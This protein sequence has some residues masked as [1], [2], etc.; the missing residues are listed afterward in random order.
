VGQK[1][2]D[3]SVQCLRAAD[4]LPARDRNI[5][6]AGTTSVC[7]HDG[8]LR[9]LAALAH[10]AP[11]SPRWP[12]KVAFFLKKSRE[13]TKRQQAETSAEKRSREVDRAIEG[14]WDEYG[15]RWIAS[16]TEEPRP[17]TT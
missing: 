7:A 4:E 15:Q 3:T 11:G 9:A 2:H 1:P 12:S 10:A 13:W 14:E 17:G 16:D 5:G 6:F 8:Y